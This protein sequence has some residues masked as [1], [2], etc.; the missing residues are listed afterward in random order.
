MIEHRKTPWGKYTTDKCANCS[1]WTFVPACVG[2]ESESKRKQ[3][4]DELLADHIKE[5]H[6]IGD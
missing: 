2:Q 1:T 5:K 3:I 4:S 6:N